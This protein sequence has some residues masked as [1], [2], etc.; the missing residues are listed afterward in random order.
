MPKQQ[1]IF[2][3]CCSIDHWMWTHVMVTSFMTSFSPIK[4]VKPFSISVVPDE[5]AVQIS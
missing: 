1:E 3:D 4:G 2:M 5:L